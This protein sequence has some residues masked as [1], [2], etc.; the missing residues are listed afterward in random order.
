MRLLV[1]QQYIV[2]WNLKHLT[3]HAERKADTG[4]GSK[5]TPRTVDKIEGKAAGERAAES[6]IMSCVNPT[7]LRVLTR[8]RTYLDTN[9][10]PSGTSSMD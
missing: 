10:D 7:N 4:C 3:R 2:H 8:Q 9:R 5:L 1:H 6:L